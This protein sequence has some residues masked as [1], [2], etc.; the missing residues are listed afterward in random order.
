MIKAHKASE[1]QKFVYALLTVRPIK[2]NNTFCCIISFQKNIYNKIERVCQE[3]RK[4]K[5]LIM[6]FKR[7]IF[8]A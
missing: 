2:I 5:N 7:N 6:G 4:L 1:A 8:W 3:T